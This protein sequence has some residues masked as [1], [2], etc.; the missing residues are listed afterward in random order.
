[1]ATLLNGDELFKLVADGYI[2]K[3]SKAQ[4]N[5]SSI[6]VTLGNDITQ[7]YTSGGASAILTLDKRDKRGAQEFNIKDSNFTL[8]PMRGIL[9]HTEQ[10]LNLPNN[11]SAQYRIKSSMARIGL[12]EAGAG[13]VDAGF[14]GGNL[15][16]ALFNTNNRHSII[17]DQGTAIGQL[18]FFKHEEVSEEFSYKTKGSYNNKKGVVTASHG[19]LKRKP[20]KGEIKPIKELTTEPPKELVVA[21]TKAPSANMPVAE[22]MQRAQRRA[23]EEAK[24][25]DS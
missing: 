16:I 25:N 12:A 10:E 15:T 23:Q 13:W 8:T 7:E 17:L 6:D 5:A 18:V 1:M 11:I 24:K 9:I 2:T 21:S 14:H 19:E 20:A 22:R 3:V 4:I